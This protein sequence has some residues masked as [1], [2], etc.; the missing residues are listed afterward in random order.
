LARKPRGA[1]FGQVGVH[2]G[3]PALLRVGR[4]GSI[5]RK[6]QAKLAA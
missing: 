1:A 3:L 5:F 6:L 2:A 4:G